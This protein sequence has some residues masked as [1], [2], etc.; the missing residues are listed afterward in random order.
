VG[1]RW[2]PVLFRARRCPRTRCAPAAGNQ[3]PRSRPDAA[4][5]ETRRHC[6]RG[7]T[8][9][10]KFICAKR[11]CH[12]SVTFFLSNQPGRAPGTPRHSTSDAAAT[13]ASATGSHHCFNRAFFR[14]SHCRHWGCGSVRGEKMRHPHTTDDIQ[15]RPSGRTRFLAASSG[16]GITPTTFYPCQPRQRPVTLYCMRPQAIRGSPDR[17]PPI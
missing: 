8:G 3:G 9:R 5:R 2:P 4:P 1:G 13:A 16:V 11:Q 12:S 6:T 14:P 15:S 7:R 17:S 10:R